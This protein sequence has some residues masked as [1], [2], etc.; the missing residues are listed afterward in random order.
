MYNRGY[1]VRVEIDMPEDLRD[2][3]RDWAN[4]NGLQMKRAYAELIEKGLEVEDSE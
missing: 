2:R 3:V 4:K 1:N